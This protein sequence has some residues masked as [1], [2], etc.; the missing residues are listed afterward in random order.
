[1]GST[2]FGLIP[3]LGRGLDGLRVSAVPVG[4]VPAGVLCELW[5]GCLWKLFLTSRKIMCLEKKIPRGEPNLSP[6]FW[7][8]RSLFSF[9]FLSSP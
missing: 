1:M 5:V 7:K 6:L 2:R 4:T 9:P 8:N 3:G